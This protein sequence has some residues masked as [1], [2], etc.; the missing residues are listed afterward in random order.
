ML[1]ALVRRPPP[2]RLVDNCQCKLDFNSWYFFMMFSVHSQQPPKSSDMLAKDSSR[3]SFFYSTFNFYFRAYTTHIF[4]SSRLSEPWVKR[5]EVFSIRLDN[6]PPSPSRV[7][8]LCSLELFFIFSCNNK[9]KI[10]HHCDF[11]RVFICVHGCVDELLLDCA[12]AFFISDE[13]EN[14]AMRSGTI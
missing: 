13:E 10:F 4:T 7:G 14:K 2:N 1:N 5:L 9:N 12:L 3:C 6:P 8:N 11:S